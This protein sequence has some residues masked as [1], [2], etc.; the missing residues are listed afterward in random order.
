M[1]KLHFGTLSAEVNGPGGFVIFICSFFSGG[2]I[3]SGKG[4]GG[5][6]HHLV[7]GASV[8]YV[9]EGSVGLFCFICEGC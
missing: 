3:L 1:E 2:P 6:F 5:W 7:P 8:P 4:G 9:R